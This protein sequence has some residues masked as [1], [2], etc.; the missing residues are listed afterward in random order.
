MEIAVSRVLLQHTGLDSH[1]LL[2]VSLLVVYT[3]TT[4]GILAKKTL[5][6]DIRYKDN[7]QE[8]APR[9]TALVDFLSG[10]AA[11]ACLAASIACLSHTHGA[12]K[13]EAVACIIV[14]SCALALRVL[15]LTSSKARGNLCAAANA[16]GLGIFAASTVP[17]YV[18]PA[19]LAGS[20]W[21]ISTLSAAELANV[22]CTIL[23]AI[24]LPLVTPS[25]PG[26]IPGDTPLHPRDTCAPITKWWTY[27]WISPFV[28]ASY[29]S[30]ARGIEVQNL[31][32]LSQ[33]S[34]PDAWFVAFR[35]ECKR[36]RSSAR[37]LWYLFRPR[38]AAMAA[39]MV[40]CGL[41]ELLGS[42]GLRG[43]LTHLEG[44]ASLF[45]PWFSA[46]LFGV[47]PVVRGLF[48]QTF[49]YLSTQGIC[50]LKSTVICTVH[51]KLLKHRPGQRPDA[52]RI[53]NHI[54]A[55]VDKMATLRYSIMAGFMVPVEVVTASL[56]LY[57]TIGWAYVPGLLVILLTRVPISWYVNRYQGLAQTRVMAAVDARV[58]RVGEVVRALQ[59]IKMLGRASAFTA[60]IDEKRQAELQ[61][62]WRKLIIM[63]VSE[64][65]SSAFVLVPLTMSL[66][67]YTLGAGMPLTPSVA[68][69]VAAVFKTLK[70]MLSLAVIG[71]STYAQGTASLRRVVLFLD[72]D[73][74]RIL[75]DETPAVSSGADS[76]L[77]GKLFGARDATVGYYSLDGSVSPV[78]RHCSFDLVTGGLNVIVGKTGS[79]KST[80][81]KALLGEQPVV[82]GYMSIGAKPD[83]TISYAGQAPWLRRGTIRDNIVFNSAFSESRYQEVIHAVALDV[84][85]ASTMPDGDL[86]DVGE[87]GSALSGGQRARVAL[88]RAVYAGTKTVLLDN[89][90]SALDAATASWVADRCIL[91]PLMEGRSTV[92]VTENARCRDSAH[93]LI[94]LGD[95]GVQRV[96]SSNEETLIDLGKGGTELKVA[97]CEVASVAS[98]STTCTEGSVLV[99]SSLPSTIASLNKSAPQS[100]TTGAAPVEAIMDGLSGRFYV[101]KLLKL[102]GSAPYLTAL[103]VA[104]LCTHASDVASSFSLALWSGT[105]KGEAGEPDQRSTAAGYLAAFTA[106]GIAQLALS[107]GSSFLFFRGSLTASRKE[108]ASMLASVLGATYAWITS[109][110]AGQIMNRFS[111]DMFSLDNTVTEL[112]KQVVENYLA[113]GFRL[114]A[115]SSMLP[116]FLVPA[117]VL[118]GL[119]LLTGQVYSYGSTAAKQLYAASLSPLL[120]GVSDAVAGIEVIRAHRAEPAFREQF[121]LALVQ[122]LRGWE[123][124]SACQRWLAVRMDVYAGLISLSTAV[125]AMMSREASPATVGFSMT[126]S[127]TLC[128]ALLYVVYLSSLLEVEMS[129]FRR[130]EQYIHNTP[131]E[132]FVVAPVPPSQDLAGWPPR[133]RVELRG[134]AAAYAL[135]A[136]PVLSGVN[137]VADP[138]QRIA[139]V[140]RS[141]S[142]K[143]SLVATIL[144]LAT[145]LAGC[146]TVDGVDVDTVDAE[147]LRRAVGFIPQ[148]PVLFEGSL[149]FNLDFSGT[150]PDDVLEDVLGAAMG[151][152][153]AGDDGP[154][155][156]SRHIAAQGSN[157]SQGERQLVTIARTLVSSARVVIIDEA[158]AS[159]D[160]ES[161]AR[162]QRLL[163]ARLRDRTLI[164]VAHRLETVEDFDEVLVMDGGRVV[165]RGNP[166]EL[167]ASGQGQFF[168]LWQARGTV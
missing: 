144:R 134:V 53:T 4:L 60:W 130:L 23:A 121:Q 153:G 76:Y 56:L 35:N 127:T 30:R 136:E 149:R 129:S 138:G 9:R 58:R 164:A 122:Y 19:I 47:S 99:S 36:G 31:P 166:R 34:D 7:A 44:S 110:P 17:G 111:S 66:G 109:T 65:V 24:V 89:V 126:S 145:R 118:L 143:S 93:L 88:A 75:D 108:H 64:T 21:D 87:D 123:A 133:G 113:I 29:R 157:L 92:L 83:E 148:D 43:L 12:R 73:L 18:F 77:D 69:T 3:I 45:R 11:A 16:L 112:L 151:S 102:F 159:L 160:A 119:G 26:T 80:L 63:T 70:E 132:P 105:N 120:S 156:L 167:I 106:L 32:P 50:H 98:D 20:G 147:R 162:I 62:I 52:A 141:G 86:T 72:D 54:A 131:Q 82:S 27:G 150:V 95:G 59:T 1:V 115:V 10:G 42:V 94:E 139:V 2:K 125:L 155:A 104:I 68:F 39:L 61:S 25:Q 146:V 46:A 51:H 74:E 96:T 38:L 116:T 57:D 33:G 124:V 5:R 142:G 135:D 152:S 28:L 168:G 14:W 78:L 6:T 79:G 165:E 84:D 40:L 100:S 107:T 81:L 15:S 90:L 101:L 128:T 85:F 41:S 22:S 114:A 161:D 137:L 91:G 158:T 103:C 71:V 8:R 117:T 140:G 163:R 49:E 97:E 37:A 13:V 67:I 154:W 55:D 48:M